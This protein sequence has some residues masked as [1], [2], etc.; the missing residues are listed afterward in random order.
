MFFEC[1]SLKVFWNS[2]E[3]YWDEK[4]GEHVKLSLKEVILGKTD[5]KGNLFNFLILLAKHF[6]FNSKMKGCIPTFMTFHKILLEK[7]DLEKVVHLRKGEDKQFKDKW[8]F[9]P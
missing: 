9:E 4:T 8:I 7:Y 5:L 6:I 1:E 3:S 2:F